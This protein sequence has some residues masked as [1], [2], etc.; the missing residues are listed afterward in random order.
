MATVRAVADVVCA[1]C[2]QTCAHNRAARAEPLV[3]CYEC[4]SAAH[5]TCLE[6]DSVILKRILA[7]D[8]KCQ[9]CKRCEVCHQNGG[10]EVRPARPRLG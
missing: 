7:Y 1:F 8:W 9:D 4:G 10:S 5:P 6:F 3:S 2:Q